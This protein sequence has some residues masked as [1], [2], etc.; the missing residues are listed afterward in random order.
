M[1]DYVLLYARLK[2]LYD[3]KANTLS[4]LANTA[5]VLGAQIEDISWAGFYLQDD[6]GLYLAPFYGE[7]ACMNIK[8]G[9][10]VCGTAAKTD[11]LQMVDD[12]SLY[13]GHIACSAK[14]RSE[15]VLPIHKNGKVVG[16]LDIDSESLARFTNADAQGLAEIVKL[17]EASLD[18]DI[19]KK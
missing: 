18:F 1:T 10:G 16:V 6:E 9:K 7:A 13:A 12:V 17:M 8:N 14:T 5:A 15:I 19:F 2:G 4:C 3:G 11:K